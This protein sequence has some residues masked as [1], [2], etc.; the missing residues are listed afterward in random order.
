M[1]CVPQIVIDERTHQMNK[2][3][4]ELLP[5]LGKLERVIGHNLGITPAILSERINACVSSRVTELDLHVIALDCSRVYWAAMVSASVR[6]MPPFDPGEKEKGFRDAVLLETFLQTIDDSPKS[7]AQCM[8]VFVSGD[9][10]LRT[11]ATNKTAAFKNARVLEDMTALDELVNTL[12]STL[13][14]EYVA[15]L[16]PTAAALFFVSGATTGLYNTAKVR[17]TIERTF[18]DLIDEVPPGCTSVKATGFRIRNPSFLRK[19]SST[20]FWETICTYMQV[21]TRSTF[22]SSLLDATS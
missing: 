17:A 10:V 7:P 20:V 8:V 4:S 22:E 1:W 14:E 6:R 5:S 12:S 19:A 18:Q 16:R 3:A 11:A 2:V 21:V 13:T 9:A 15:K